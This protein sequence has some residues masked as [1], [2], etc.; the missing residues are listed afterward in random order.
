MPMSELTINLLGNSTG[1]ACEYR[2]IPA[3]SPALRIEASRAHT[4]CIIIPPSLEPFATR[5]ELRALQFFAEKTIGQ[6]TAFFPDQVWNPIIL[7]SARSEPGIRHGLLALATYHE[8]FLG[9]S[10]K[11]EES[12]F[13]LSQYNKAIKALLRPDQCPLSGFISLL[14]CLIFFCIEVRAID[15]SA[16]CPAKVCFSRFFGGS[17]RPP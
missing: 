14:S 8:R 7:Q 16:C 6:F 12:L 17:T 9:G 15:I 13:A 3:N 4:D 2:P 11:E 5:Q 1:R 10:N